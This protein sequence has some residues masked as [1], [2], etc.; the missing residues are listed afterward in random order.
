MLTFTH[1]ITELY[2]A[3]GFDY[4]EKINQH[5]HKHGVLTPGHTSA[6]SSGDAPDSSIRVG[7]KDHSL[8]IKK[9]KNAMMGQLELHHHPDKGWHISDKSKQKYPATA[10]HIEKSGFLDHVNK[11]WSKPSGDYHKDLKMGNVYHTEK[12][13]KGIQAHYGKDRKTPY[14]HIGGHGTYHTGSDVAKTGVPE[15]S[16]NTQ[17]RARMKYRGTDKKTGKKKYGALIVM[18]L[19]EPEK[20]SHDL[21]KDPSFLKK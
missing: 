3:G 17:L 11:Q 5:L 12:G 18:G 13:T 1:F 7:G 8:E 4:E 2:A 16:G 10:A 9:N 6:G 14:I 15:L 21:E 19:K 20:S